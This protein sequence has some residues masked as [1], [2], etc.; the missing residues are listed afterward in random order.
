M[1]IVFALCQSEDLFRE[2]Q[3]ALAAFAPYFGEHHIDAQRAALFFHQ[4]QLR[5]GISREA[6]DG[7][8]ARQ[9]VILCH[10]LNMLQQVRKS[11]FESFQVLAVQFLFRHAAV[12]F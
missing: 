8:D 6:V 5:L 12:V 10:V 1:E 4:R 2:R 3:A 7:N 11:F 9:S